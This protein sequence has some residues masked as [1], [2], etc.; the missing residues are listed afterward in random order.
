MTPLDTIAIA[1]A[2]RAEHI[3]DLDQHR[4]A[5]EV[6]RG[7]IQKMDL[8]IEWTQE[9]LQED[10]PPFLQADLGA[11][12]VT[13]TEPSISAPLSPKTADLVTT[14]APPTDDDACPHDPD[15][16]HFIGCGCDAEDQ[17]DTATEAGGFDSRSLT[18]IEVK[19]QVQVLPGVE[20][21]KG[22]PAG[23]GR[24]DS[25]ESLAAGEAT[26]SPAPVSEN[27]E[28]APQAGEE[29][30][31][32]PAP[33]TEATGKPVEEKSSAAPRPLTKQEMV[34]RCHAEHPDWPQ[35]LIAEHT[36]VGRGSVSAYVSMLGIKVPTLAEYEAAQAAAAAPAPSEP[37]ATETPPAKSYSPAAAI[38]QLVKTIEQRVGEV[39]ATNPHWTASQIAKY[40]VKPEA[41]I[42]PIL[43]DVIAADKRQQSAGTIG[44]PGAEQRDR[45]AEVRKRLGVV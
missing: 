17:P 41:T 12:K 35:K 3:A 20:D 37:P 8:L 14:P 16:Q 27:A 19:P 31:T 40:L 39:H 18:E 22:G 21:A 43:R 23:T 10:E 32:S 26:A 34:R 9:L 13:T 44:N 4:L 11:A 6:L 2:R 28:A 36:G 15:G 45:Y 30:A 42:A 25:G 29:S 33:T 24:S 7:E 1:K 5:A 38:P